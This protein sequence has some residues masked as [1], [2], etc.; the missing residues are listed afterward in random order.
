[1]EFGKVSGSKNNWGIS[2]VGRALAWHARG[3]RFEPAIL[4]KP[5]LGLA[6]FM[7]NYV[8]IIYSKTLDSYYTGETANLEDRL[9]R[10]RNSGSKST[11]KAKDWELKF[12]EK[13][14]SRVLARIKETEI[15][16]K[17][18]RKYIE[19]ILNI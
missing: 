19:S 1:M 10:H 12:L 3:Q 6:F 17:K 8:Y 4:H 9:F 7:P 13:F 5:I 14:D 16:N 18:S 2:S 11:K 15:K